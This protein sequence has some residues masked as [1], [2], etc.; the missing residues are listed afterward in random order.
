MK[1]LDQ[2]DANTDKH[3]IER[4][5]PL[6]YVSERAQVCS[7]VIERNLK[8]TIR[9]DGTEFFGWQRQPERRTVQETIERAIA[10]VTREE[11]M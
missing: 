1:L 7:L 8:L 9:Y 10:A 11:R 3:F 4:M 2:R 5:E 6:A